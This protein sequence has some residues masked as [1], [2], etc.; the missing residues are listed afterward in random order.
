MKMCMTQNC[1]CLIYAEQKPPHCLTQGTKLK[2]VSILVPWVKQR[3]GFCSA[4]IKHTVWLRVPKYILALVWSDTF[5]LNFLSDRLIISGCLSLEYY[6]QRKAVA[7]AYLD[8]RRLLTFK[9]TYFPLSIVE[10][11][12]TTPIPVCPYSP[13]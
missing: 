3:G 4:C 6:S 12:I 2:P 1:L 8:L 11:V 13:E 5:C 7:F 9:L 10:Y